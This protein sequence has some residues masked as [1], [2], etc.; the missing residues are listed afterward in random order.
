MDI[1]AA[2]TGGWVAIWCAII[3]F[4]LIVSVEQE[5]GFVSLIATVVGILALEVSGATH[6]WNWAYQNPFRWIALILI[7]LTCGA[8][9]SIVKWWFYV[10]KSRESVRAE[11]GMWQSVHPDGSID[12][13]LDSPSNRLRLKN[14]ENKNR[15]VL[16]MIW[17][18]PSLVWT[19]CSDVVLD[20]WHKIYDLLSSIYTNI[21]KHVIKST[22][23]KF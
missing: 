18:I 10:R 3:F 1:L 13:F 6:I 14:G 2:F 16:W 7:Y 9:W 12:E 21:A 8:A 22:L 19:V 5:K 15:I 17:W 11:Y 4:I 23:G 20:I